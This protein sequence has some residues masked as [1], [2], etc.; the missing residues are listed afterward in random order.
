[1][2]GSLSGNCFYIS[3]TDYPLTAPAV[4]PAVI[5]RW[6]NKVMMIIGIVTITHAA[7]IV[8]MGL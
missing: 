3:S 6:K 1:M 2:A 8:P 5:R 7:V 4:R